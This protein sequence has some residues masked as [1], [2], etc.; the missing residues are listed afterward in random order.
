MKVT[1]KDGSIKEYAESMSANDI[2]FD[3]AGGLG[4][5]ACAAEIDGEPVDLRTMVDQDCTLNIL[6]FK[7]E[8]GKGAYRH[9]CSHVMAEA[10]KKL[11]PEA[12]L[13]IGPKVDD[14]F[15]Y[16]TNNLFLFLSKF[17]GLAV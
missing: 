10:V 14:G 5:A 12:K 17:E 1:L 11:F 9:T 15:S 16:R 6:T 2:A 8:F 3:I 4:R 7:D 13:A